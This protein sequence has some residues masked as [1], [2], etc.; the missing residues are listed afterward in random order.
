MTDPLARSRPRAGRDDRS[1]LR[2]SSP[3]QRCRG[4]VR[5]VCERMALSAAVVGL[6]RCAWRRRRA[7]RSRID[8]RHRCPRCRRCPT[9]AS[10]PRPIVVD[11]D[12][13]LLRPFTIADGRW[14]LPVDAGPTSTRTSSTMLI[15]YEDR[16]FA[17]HDGVDCDGAGPRRRAVRARRRPH[18]LRRLDAD[19]AGGAAPRRRRHAEHRRQAPPDR[20]WRGRSK[21]RFSKDEILDLYLT[22]A[23]YGGNIEGIRAAS[24]AYFGKEPTRLTTAEAALL[25]ALPQSPEARRPDRDPDAARAA[26]DRVLDRLAGAGRHRRRRRRGGEDRARCRRRGGRSRCSPRTSPCRR[27]PPHPERRSTASPSTAT[28]RRRS[29]R[30][31]PTAPPRSGRSCRWRSSS[32][33]TLT[34]AILASVGSAGLFEDERDG[35]VDMT[36]GVRSPGSTLKPLIYGLAFEAGP[37]PSGEPDRGPADRLRRLRAGEF[38]RLPPRHGDD[39]RGADPVAQRPGDHRARRGRPGAAGGAAEARRGR[40]RCSPTCS[41]P[42]LAVGLGGVGVTL[43]DLVALYA[44]IARGGT[45]VAL[46]DGVDDPPPRAEPARR[47]CRRRAAWYVA[48]ILA[49]VPPPINGSPGRDRLQDRHLLRL[50]RRLGDRLRRRARRRRLGRPAGRHA[51]PRP[52]RHRQRGAD[53]VRGVRPH[54]PEARRRSRRRRRDARSRPPPSCRRRS[55]ASATR[56]RRS[57]SATATRRSPSRSTASPSISASRRAIRRRW[58]SRSATARRPSPSSPTACR[59]AARRSPARRPGSRTAPAS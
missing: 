43:R 9:R 7:G 10:R 1:D 24:L 48:D 33:T 40:R 16:R 21:R 6:P 35:Y 38:R 59:S 57:S 53:P 45:P 20:R 36:R 23:P 56:T 41:A 44:A 26:R 4:G 11:R 15:G 19:H 27:S 13:R 52:L 14:R 51:G 46:R 49:G 50:S 22:L 31:P 42:G 55:A 25:V 18:R 28:C 39:P 12:G 37:R 30:S 54:R 34:G 47:C 5:R 3:P 17:E 58:S 2:R 8:A 32:P 29:R